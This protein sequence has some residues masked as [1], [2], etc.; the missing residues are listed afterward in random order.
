MQGVLNIA[1]RAAALALPDVGPPFIQ[2][3]LARTAQQANTV[4]TVCHTHSIVQLHN[5]TVL[6]MAGRAQECDCIYMVCSSN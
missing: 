4:M 3:A 2:A 1:A 5:P 6:F